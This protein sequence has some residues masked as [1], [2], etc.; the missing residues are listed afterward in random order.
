MKL[1]PWT[2]PAALVL[3]LTVAGGSAHAQ[4]GGYVRP[5]SNPFGTPVFSPYLNLLQRGTNPAI[6]YYGIVRPEIQTNNALRTL[7]GDVNA[8]AT[9]LS[10]DQ[11]QANQIATGHSVQFLNTTHYFMNTTGAGGTARVGSQPN[12]LVGVGS[13]GGSSTA[14]A[15]PSKPATG[16]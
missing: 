5:Y 15:K 2:L 1:I 10:A 14:G 11:A 4:G 3:L 9:A 7:Q 16:K 6:N 8:N 12:F 13:A